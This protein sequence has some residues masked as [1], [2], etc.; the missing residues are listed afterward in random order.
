MKLEKQK[1][2]RLIHGVGFKEM[3]LEVW[4]GSPRLSPPGGAVS[5]PGQ[6]P[7]LQ[8]A[9]PLQ[10]PRRVFLGASKSRFK[11]WK[12]MMFGIKLLLQGCPF[13]SLCPEN[14][15]YFWNEAVPL[16]AVTSPWSPPW[17]KKVVEILP[18]TP[19]RLATSKIRLVR[20]TRCSCRCCEP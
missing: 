2:K 20:R 17:N 12:K 13:C 9:A 7:Y 1:L 8:A 6:T 16:E 4:V 18:L 11:L 10:Y 15:N 3:N 5:S 19:F 14:K